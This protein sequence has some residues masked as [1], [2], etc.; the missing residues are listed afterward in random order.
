M[1]TMSRNYRNAIYEFDS[2]SAYVR[3]TKRTSHCSKCYWSCDLSSSEF[4]NGISWSNDSFGSNSCGLN[5][6][7]LLSTGQPYCIWDRLKT[8]LGYCP[9][10]ILRSSNPAA[11]IVLNYAVLI[12]NYWR[13][14]E[15]EPCEPRG[16]LYYCGFCTYRALG[17]RFFIAYSVRIVWSDEIN[18]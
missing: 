13:F 9:V 7:T 14:S 8:G 1:Y 5:G 12:E 16:V 6:N 18:N 17:G 10:Y 3:I 4:S 2:V 11:G 15:E